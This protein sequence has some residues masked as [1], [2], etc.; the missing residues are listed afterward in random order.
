MEVRPETQIKARIEDQM[1]GDSLMKAS[2][3]PV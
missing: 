2:T 3:G 1:A